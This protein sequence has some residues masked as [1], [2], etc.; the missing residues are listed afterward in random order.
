MASIRNFRVFDFA[1]VYYF[2]Q[3]NS[4]ARPVSVGWAWFDLRSRGRT[5]HVVGLHDGGKDLNF[6]IRFSALKFFR[7]PK[8][9]TGFNTNR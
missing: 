9:Q 1:S 2:E 5:H 4:L 6:L 8:D 7:I 3:C